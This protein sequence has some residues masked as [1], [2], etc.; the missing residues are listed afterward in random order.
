[1]VGA[2]LEN[3]LLGEV[4]R[5]NFRFR[6]VPQPSEFSTAETASQNSTLV[7]VKRKYLLV[8]F[9]VEPG[10]SV[11]DCLDLARDR[12]VGLTGRH[13]PVVATENLDR[14]VD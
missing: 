1:M 9:A 4:G 6:I 2:D 5:T 12:V 11:I 8:N 14:K 10:E 3:V 13:W 7:V